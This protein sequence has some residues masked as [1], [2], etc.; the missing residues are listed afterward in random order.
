[1]GVDAGL[2]EWVAEALAPIGHVSHR[3]MM[4]GATLYCDGTIFGIAFEDSLWFKAD[5]D[6][7][8]EWDAAGCARF[9]YAKGDGTTGSMNYRRA[10]DDVYDDADAMQLWARL[11][12]AA[13]VR[14]PAPKAKRKR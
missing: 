9:T 10:P 14:A 2:V 12:L 4:G 1:M 11:A 13:G 5:A 8:A 7:D 6:S 3:R